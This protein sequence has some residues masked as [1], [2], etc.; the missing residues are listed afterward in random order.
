MSTSNDPDEIRA[1]I[2]HTRAALSADVDALADTANPKHIAQ[3][4]VG[5]LKDAAVGVKEHIMGSATDTRDDAA[6]AIGDAKDAVAAKAS[7]LS[8]AVGD[9]PARAK[10]KT[11]GNPLGAGLVAFGIGL[12]ISG[13]IPSTSKEREA[14][15]ALQEKVEPLKEQATQAVKEVAQN[16]Q[17]P[18]RDAAASV[19]S[20]A[21]DAADAVKSEGTQA[22]DQ[23]QDQVSESK[24][25]VQQS[26]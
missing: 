1:N 19:K 2:E 4:Q 26:V 6:A 15:G 16:L 25:N 22:R 20:A 12:F 10:Q 5:K 14:V 9:A 23:V 13:L 11:R 18:A 8:S 17:E 7:G 24:D 3:R 21:T